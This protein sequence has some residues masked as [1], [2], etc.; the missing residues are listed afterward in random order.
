MNKL[1]LLLCVILIANISTENKD[2]VE[3][4]YEILINILN[5]MSNDGKNGKCA[6][7]FK[8]KKN[9][10]F[11]IFKDLVNEFK[12]GKSLSEMV[13]SY[14]LKLLAI[15]DIAVSCKAFS[16]F[17][18]FSKITSKEGIK[19]IGVAIEKNADYIYKIV[20]SIKSNKVFEDKVRYA[21]QILSKIFDFSVY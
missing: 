5:G 18:L 10:I 3:K 15:E 19:D 17:E 21:G 1:G 12:D 13:P 9:E 14:G 4:T 7:I 2:M 8:D 16:L 11:P 6:Q 20:S